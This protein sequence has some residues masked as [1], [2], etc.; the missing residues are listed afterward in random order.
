LVAQHIGLMRTDG[1]GKASAIL[2]SDTRFFE[3]FAVCDHL[4]QYGKVGLLTNV[5]EEGAPIAE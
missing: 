2:F 5:R 3:S 4:V 1:A